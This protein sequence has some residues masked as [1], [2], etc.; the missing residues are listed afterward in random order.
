MSSHQKTD[1][2]DMAARGS[3][4]SRSEVEMQAGA[5]VVAGGEAKR[6][7]PRSDFATAGSAPAPPPTVHASS[8]P[9]PLDESLTLASPMLGGTH[10]HN[11]APTGS[12]LESSQFGYANRNDASPLWADTSHYLSA[13]PR[14]EAHFNVPPPVPNTSTNALFPLT[15]FEGYNRG[16]GVTASQLP[17][18]SSHQLGA[19]NLSQNNDY[20][21]NLGYIADLTVLQQNALPNN[22]SLLVWPMTAF[23]GANRTVPSNPFYSHEGATH[24]PPYPMSFLPLAM[25]RVSEPLPQ[26]ASLSRAFALPNVRPPRHAH[27]AS[28]IRGLWTPSA[29]Q[30]APASVLR[31]EWHNSNLS[32]L[33]HPPRSTL[34]F[35]SLTANNDTR[36][37]M[38]SAMVQPTQEGGAAYRQG[39]PVIAPSLGPA[40]FAST[41]ATSTAL[42]VATTKPHLYLPK[43]LAHPKDELLLSG[44][45]VLL[46]Q[47]IEVFEATEQDSKTTFRGRN[48][49]IQVGQVG[50]RCRHCKHVPSFQRQPGSMYFPCST[51]GIYQASQNMSSTHLQCGLCHTMPEALRQQFAELIPTKMT[52]SMAGRPYWTNCAIEMG[53]VDTEDGIRFCP[54]E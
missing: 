2:N 24:V 22:P 30:I 52:G 40:S 50:I 31:T 32:G 38:E 42:D 16:L 11:N 19:V 36:S 21:G 27:A 41:F 3:K 49:R 51:T 20:T 37:I 13:T 8:F 39:A 5:T 14:T 45:Q 1:S 47:Q 53:L 34:G 25:P 44:H 48:R 10:Y 43:T 33:H 26:H 17:R 12:M 4:R 15:T 28:A 54:K 9:K 6:G 18:L 7:R 23:A 29:E 46:R 35:E